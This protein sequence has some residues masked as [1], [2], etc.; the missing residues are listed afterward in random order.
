MHGAGRV[1]WNAEYFNSVIVSIAIE[2]R[3]DHCNNKG[4]WFVHL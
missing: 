2:S 1:N 3:E 4:D